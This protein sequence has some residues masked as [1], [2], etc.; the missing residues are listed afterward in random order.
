MKKRF[1]TLLLCLSVYIVQATTP[2]D[3]AIAEKY[4]KLIELNGKPITKTIPKE[5]FFRLSKTIISGNSSCNSFTGSFERGPA[6]RIRFS[7]IAGTLMACMN[8][9]TEAPFLALLQKTD[10][11]TL[12][13][14]TL[15]LSRARMAPLARFVAVTK[16][17]R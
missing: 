13:K 9:T 15:T 8:N 14:D 10:S 11:Y 1:F 7:K 17:K 3:T 12:R 2:S 5:A 6:N 4:W 16:D